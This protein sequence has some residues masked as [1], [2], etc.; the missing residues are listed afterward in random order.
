MMRR[1]APAIAALAACSPPPQGATW[2]RLDVAPA[3]HFHGAVGLGDEVWAFGATVPPRS[4]QIHFDG[5]DWREDLEG[6]P[7]TALAGASAADYSGGPSGV[8]DTLLSPSY[9]EGPFDLLRVLAD[10]DD[11][12]ELT[13]VWGTGAED[14]WVTALVEDIDDPTR[15]YRWDGAAWS[16]VEAVRDVGEWSGLLTYERGCSSEAGRQWIATNKIDG[17]PYPQI[18][19][20]SETGWSL[21]IWHSAVAFA[22]Q[23]GGGVVRALACAGASIWPIVHVENPTSSD[24]VA[25]WEGAGWGGPLQ[26]EQTGSGVLRLSGVWA[27]DARNGWVVGAE[28]VDG[29]LEPRVW[30]VMDRRADLVPLDSLDLPSL[31]AAEGDDYSVLRAVWQTASGRVFVFGVDG[32]V[33]ELGG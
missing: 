13:D 29:S 15:V 4:E 14:I 30:R 22:L 8:Q 31:P 16:T 26:L 18:L 12:I 2:R 28:D 17:G 6:A 27:A 10:S 11:L 25:I 20:G 24:M 7:L 1:W 21:L 32:I 33:L 3:V 19:H 23:D 5:R 9:G